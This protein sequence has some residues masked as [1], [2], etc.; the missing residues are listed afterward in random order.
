MC[1]NC[2]AR[3]RGSE[4][5]EISRVR[6]FGEKLRPVPAASWLQLSV[7]RGPPVASMPLQMSEFCASFAGSS[8]RPCQ[9]DISIFT[10]ELIRTFLQCLVIGGNSRRLLRSMTDCLAPLPVGCLSCHANRRPLY[11]HLT[12]LEA[13]QLGF[14][15]RGRYITSLLCYRCLHTSYISQLLI[16]TVLIKTRLIRSS[17]L[18]LVRTH[19]FCITCFQSTSCAVILTTTSISEQAVSPYPHRYHHVYPARRALLRLQVSLL[20]SCG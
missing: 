12:T 19:T 13:V 5:K 9:V 17:S 11:R 15:R 14:K 7:R 4:I 16:S 8:E 18:H 10:L 1:D 6:S 20:P 3:S 2:K